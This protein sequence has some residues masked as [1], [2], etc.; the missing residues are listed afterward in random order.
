MATKKAPKKPAPKKSGKLKAAD[1]IVVSMKDGDVLGLYRDG[2][3][4]AHLDAL[5]NA[6][7]ILTAQ[8]LLGTTKKKGIEWKPSTF[9]FQSN[10]A[11]RVTLNFEGPDCMGEWILAGIVLGERTTIIRK[12]GAFFVQDL[13]R[14]EDQKE[15]VKVWK[16]WFR[17]RES[18][19]KIPFA[20]FRGIKAVQ[21]D[22]RSPDT[23]SKT[24]KA[25]DLAT[26]QR[27]SLRKLLSRLGLSTKI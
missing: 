14:T 9:T 12:K 17:W 16:D 7:G 11:E 24:A 23:I 2:S 26:A 20:K 1:V 4:F 21:I 8:G 25:N 3:A 19:V 6:T 5:G 13:G 22:Y 27:D 10:Q 18:G 15:A